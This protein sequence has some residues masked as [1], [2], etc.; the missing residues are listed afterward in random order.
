M[1][2]LIGLEVLQQAQNNNVQDGC[3]QRRL[4]EACINFVVLSWPE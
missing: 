3:E 1:S 4:H 2:A